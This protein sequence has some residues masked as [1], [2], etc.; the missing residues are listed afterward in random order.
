M[1]NSDIAVEPYEEI[2][3]GSGSVRRI[4]VTLPLPQGPQHC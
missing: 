1:Q 3:N 2:V 4:S